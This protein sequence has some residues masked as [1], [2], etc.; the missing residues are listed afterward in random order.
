MSIEFAHRAAAGHI[1]HTV[2]QWLTTA[3]QKHLAGADLESAMGL[4]RAT[5]V[6]ARNQALRDAGHLLDEPCDWRRAIALESAIKRYQTRIQPILKRDPDH[7]LSP[8]DVA[9]QRAFQT[10]V[11]VP[12]TARNLLEIVR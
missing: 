9:L 1:D 2:Q 5:R 7:I 12:Q 6:R 11:R 4:T 8:I 3:M 10:G